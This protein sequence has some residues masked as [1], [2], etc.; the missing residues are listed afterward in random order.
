MV[1]Q[2]HSVMAL[3]PLFLILAIS[4]IEVEGAKLFVFGDS[5]VDTGNNLN[6]SSYLRANG[7][8]ISLSQKHIIN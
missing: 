5:Y 6:S 3:L 1:K 4:A 8:Y 7:R 2:N